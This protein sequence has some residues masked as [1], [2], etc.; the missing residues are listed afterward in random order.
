MGKPDRID[1]LGQVLIGIAMLGA[2]GN[3]LF[4]LFAPGEWYAAMP[5][6]RFTGPLNTHFVRDIGMAYLACAM[7][8]AWALPNLY[9]RW[10]AALAGGLWL[11]LHAGVHAYEVI[12]GICGPGLFWADFAGVFGPPLLVLA[13]VALHLVRARIAPAGL[14]KAVVM[15]SMAKL[16]DGDYL[17]AIAA[18]PG[19]M[20]E[21]FL[22]FIPATGHRYAAPS[23]L[24]HMAR[25]GSTLVEDCGGCALIT[26]RAAL[27]DG[28]DRE[29]V[30]AALAGGKALPDDLG[31]AFAFGQA[32]ASKSPEAG[33]LGD[34]IEAI[35]GRIARLE[36]ALTASLVRGFPGLKRGL[37]LAQSCSAIRLEI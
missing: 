7:I 16:G 30:N 21:S 28:V 14:P 27:A 15:P 20:F 23:G 34:A 31:G 19:H 22:H 10:L 6:V 8:L 37:G 13:G 36:L 25:I 35:H 11:A 4:M 3:G 17:P 2:L 33:A 1:R 18:A 29:V 26:A 24:F 32:I 5:T 9:S 12:S